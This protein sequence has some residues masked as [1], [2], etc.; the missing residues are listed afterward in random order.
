MSVCGKAVSKA[1][2]AVLWRVTA[3]EPLCTCCNTLFGGA[4][5]VVAVN[6]NLE[7]QPPC[8]GVVCGSLQCC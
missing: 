6:N 2:T 8:A 4:G 1:V 7:C 5:F 3:A